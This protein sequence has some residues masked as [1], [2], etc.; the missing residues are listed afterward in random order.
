MKTRWARTGVR[1]LQQRLEMTLSQS[2]LQNELSNIPSSILKWLW[3]IRGTELNLLGCPIEHT[4]LFGLTG[5]FIIP[6][7]AFL[8]L[9]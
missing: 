9:L 3:N 8:L 5:V 6:E 7:T 1:N 4:G 2:E